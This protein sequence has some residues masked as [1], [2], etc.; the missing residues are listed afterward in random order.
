MGGNAENIGLTSTATILA[1]GFDYSGI[2][3]FSGGGTGAINGSRTGGH[4]G[5]VHVDVSGSITVLGIGA[6]SNGLSALSRGG[7]GGINGSGLGGSGGDVTV[8]SSASIS[9]VGE[10]SHGLQAI[11]QGG[12]GGINGSGTGGDG[13]AVNVTSSGRISLQGDYSDGILARS[14]GG[15]GGINGDGTG[16]DSGAVTVNNSGDITVE[17]SDGTGIRALSVAATG[18]I[19]GASINGAGS[20]VTVDVTGGRIQGGSGSGWGVSIDAGTSAI[21]SNQGA[22][23][24]LS[25][26]SIFVRGQSIEVSNF[27][28]IAGNVSFQGTGGGIFSNFYGGSFESGAF[29][30]LGGGTLTNYGVLSPGG[31]DNIQTTLMGGNFAQVTNGSQAGSLLVDADW[32]AETAD[33]IDVSGAAELSGRV[34]VNPINF[35][36]SGD[37]ANFG[38]SKTFTIL[39]ASGGVTDN[40]ITAVDTAA[41]DYELLFPDANTMDLQATINFLGFNSSGLTDN[42][43]AV[44]TSLNDVVNSGGA[45]DFFSPLASLIT[46]GQL[47]NALDQLAPMGEAGQFG[48]AMATGNSFAGQLL[49]CRVLGDGDANAFIREGQ[50]VWARASVRRFDNDSGAGGVGFEE[51]GTFYSAGAQFDI[52]GPWRVGAGVGFEQADLRTT[53]NAQSETDRLHLGAVLKYNPGPLL[54]AASITG[55]YGWS[56]NSRFVSFGGFSDVATSESDQSF[57]SGRLTAAYLLSRGHW[58]AKPQIDFALTH[59]ERDGYTEASTGGTALTVDGND[60]TVFSVS[61]SIEFGAEYDLAVV[62]VARPY[63]RGGL[64]WLDTDTFVTSAAFAGAAAGTPGFDTITTIDDVVADIGAGIDFISAEGAVLRLQYDGQFG[65]QTTQHGGAAKFSVPF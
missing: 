1:D 9:T 27:G 7:V 8:Q 32:D 42:Q 6:S 52:G 45:L 34:M 19:N 11:S 13:G 54:L 65:D 47:A 63:V 41:V 48:S 55:G 22:I 58:Y 4:G 15:I 30:E 29:A 59:L 10:F 26:N 51:T 25:G 18:A 49:S 37:P 16:G 60:E 39:T 35:P 57:L 36:S 43:K 5:A 50:C 33:R 64:T 14:S 24:A 12:D 56:D 53:S 23:T 28:A 61:P 38:L 31:A 20:S 17:G 62:G 21:L 44:G 40:G 3:V 46:Q 2:Q